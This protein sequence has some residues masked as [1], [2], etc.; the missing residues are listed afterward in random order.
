MNK[1]LIA[2]R[3]EIALRIIRTIREM[4]LSSVAVFSDIDRNMPYVKWADESV[5]IGPSL[6]SESYLKGDKLI[7]VAKACGAEAIHPGYGFLSENSKFAHQVKESGLIFIGPSSSAIES[8]GN[9]L[10]AKEAPNIKCPC[11]SGS[12]E[13]DGAKILAAVRSKHRAALFR[14]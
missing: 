7:E 5:N 12:W 1:I 9:K 2:N 13:S 4:G 3:G 10:K 14:R 11:S 6:P 8:M